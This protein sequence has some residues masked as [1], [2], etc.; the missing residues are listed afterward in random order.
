MR[1]PPPLRSPAPPRRQP[2]IGVIKLTS[3][4]RAGGTVCA[5]ICAGAAFAGGT[6]TNSLYLPLSFDVL[7]IFRTF[8]VLLLIF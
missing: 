3:Q 6:D 1:A 7:M 2:G 5:E 4:S 8:H